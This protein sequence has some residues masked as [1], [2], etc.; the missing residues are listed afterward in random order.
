MITPSISSSSATL[1]LTKK[2]AAGGKLP[3]TSHSSPASSAS[4]PLL[5]SL[6]AAVGAHDAR[7]N[8]S[9]ALVALLWGGRGTLLRLHGASALSLLQALAR[10]SAGGD[11]GDSP[12]AAAYRSAS[13]FS[14]TIALQL[15]S[16]S[17]PS[18]SSPDGS[19]SYAVQALLRCPPARLA[20]LLPALAIQA[21]VYAAAAGASPTAGGPLPLL[22]LAVAADAPATLGRQLLWS[23]SAL[24]STAAS[25]ALKAA[26][27][28]LLK[29]LLNV[30]PAVATPEAAL[31]SLGLTALVAACRRAGASPGGRTARN[32]TLRAALGPG[33]LTLPHTLRLPLAP[34]SAVIP[35]LFTRAARSGALAKAAV[36]VLGGDVSGG[37]RGDVT[38][39]PAAASGGS[40]GPSRQA[41]KPGAAA[42]EDSDSSDDDDD[43]GGAGGGAGG[44][45]FHFRPTTSSAAGAAAATAV[46][47]AGG[48]EAAGS[49]SSA[50]VLQELDDAQALCLA[51]LGVFSDAVAQ[52]LPPD[53]AAAPHV[54]LARLAQSAAASRAHRGGS[55]E[56][57][58]AV[59]ACAG[60]ASDGVAAAAPCAALTSTAASSSVAGVTSTGGGGAAAA[61]ASYPALVIRWAQARQQAQQRAAADSPSSP[62]ATEVYPPPPPPVG[63]SLPWAGLCVGAPLPLASRVLTAPSAAASAAASSLRR[64]TRCLV[65]F[66][67]A[68][69]LDEGAPGGGGGSDLYPDSVRL[70]AHLPRPIR[71]RDNR[72]AVLV[73][74]AAD[75]ASVMVEA[76]HASLANAAATHWRAAGLPVG[77]YAVPYAHGLHAAHSRDPVMR[78][79]ASQCD[80]LTTSSGSG[81]GDG[82][83]VGARLVGLQIA[84][85]DCASLA[86]VLG[87]PDDDLLGGDAAAALDY[88]GSPTSSSSSSSIGGGSGGYGRNG[89]QRWLMAQL[90]N[91]FAASGSGDADDDVEVGSAAEGGGGG[92]SEGQYAAVVRTYLHSLAACLV[93]AF[94]LELGPRR[95]GDVLVAPTGHVVL[96]GLSFTDGA[97]PTPVPAAA[98]LQGSGG[99][100]GEAA[101]EPRFG[102]PAL[103]ADLLSVLGTA[104]SS[105]SPAYHQQQQ[106]QQGYDGQS[107]QARFVLSPALAQLLAASVEAYTA[108]RSG[109]AAEELGALRRAYEVRII[110]E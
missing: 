23:W 69:D 11:G 42:G 106:Q 76:L 95:P 29:A 92:D 86:E 78:N 63:V 94:V 60:P 96:A 44:G 71:F 20:V 57:R 98:E 31:Q 104:S 58:P 41:V 66:A 43:E 105:S 7:G 26:A 37:V 34:L 15:L 19:S 99:G 14:P 8:A 61:L 81:R 38:S 33:A 52:G 13:P 108:L 93:T 68:R 82:F 4:T 103:V 83:G 53:V 90:F 77:D 50:D 54:L 100:G 56:H 89:L 110:F 80:V 39:S 28:S 24:A 22:L 36:G 91:K 72:V 102:S 75:D 9:P 84:P 70:T 79:V 59:Y 32:A 65:A 25:L 48:G 30:L 16:S 109:V 17:S 107:E 1:A 46:G 35:S 18:S 21:V 5:L 74:A 49:S 10:F 2:G 62:S 97:P 3:A 47:A 73:T 12:L 45:S 27:G 88:L 67:T 40:A 87:V 55:G 6:A 64:P 51:S 101:W 85:P